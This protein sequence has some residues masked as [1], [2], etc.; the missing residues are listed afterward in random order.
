MTGLGLDVHHDQ[1]WNKHGTFETTYV[2]G[3]ADHGDKFVVKVGT[4]K[5]F[6]TPW[7]HTV[8]GR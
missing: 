5:R 6:G 8:G 2:L 3:D 1:K 4:D 7:F